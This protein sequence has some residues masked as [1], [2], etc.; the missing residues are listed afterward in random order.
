MKPVDLTI[1]VI[2]VDGVI[3]VDQAIQDYRAQ[4]ADALKKSFES[5]Y[6]Q[7]LGLT[8]AVINETS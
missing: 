2:E 1:E 4:L 5:Q 8:G 7:L 6:G 3:D